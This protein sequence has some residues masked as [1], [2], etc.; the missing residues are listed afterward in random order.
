[1]YPSS[2][3]LSGRTARAACFFPLGMAYRRAVSLS[4]SLAI[5]PRQLR[6][7]AS[8]PELDSSNKHEQ[9][10]RERAKPPCLAENN[11]SLHRTGA[12]VQRRRRRSR[13]DFDP[14]CHTPYRSNGDLL[15]SE[16]DSSGSISTAIFLPS[17]IEFPDWVRTK[18]RQWMGARTEFHLWL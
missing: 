8:R 9:T 16:T 18:A 2:A 4:H 10:D 15:V 1:M 11:G 17:A 7:L 5:P 12:K 13:A 6:L 3:Q 14:A